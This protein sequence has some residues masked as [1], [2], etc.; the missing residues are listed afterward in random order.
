MVS[1]SVH[2]RELNI[3]DA[4]RLDSVGWRGLM[5]TS[6]CRLELDIDLEKRTLVKHVVP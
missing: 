6:D 5:R 4:D 2:D 3:R 1:V